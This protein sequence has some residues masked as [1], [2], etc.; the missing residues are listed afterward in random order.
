[1]STRIYVPSD[2]TACALGADEVAAALRGEVERRGLDA[3]IVRTGSRAMYWLEPLIE[4]DSAVGR[5][6]FSNVG[7]E[8]VG[9]LFEAGFPS[10]CEVVQATGPVV[11]IPFLK[12]QERLSFRRAGVV[13]PVSLDDYR[14]HGGLSGLERAL[15]LEPRQIVE[16]IRISGLRGRGGAAF[17][18]GI[19]WQAVHDAAPGQKYIVCNAE[20]GDSGNYADR[21]MLESDPFQ[22]I[23]GM[24]I[25]GIA[26]GASRGYIYLRSEYPKA[27]GILREAIAAAERGG[28]LGDDI[29]GS[30][31]PFRLELRRG[32]GSYICGEET[33]LLNSLEGGRGVV[34]AKPP[35]PAACGLFGRPTLVS[36]VLTLAAAT[37][38]LEHGGASYRNLGHDR[39][40]GTL[41]CQ[42]GGNIRRGGLV[43]LA[44]GET[45]RTLLEDFGGGSASGRP[46]RAVQVGGPLGAYLPPSQWDT[47]LDYEAFAAIDAMV[48]H[49]GIVAF[50][51]TV[52]MG[53][54]ARYAME[55]CAA[56][57]CG[58]CTPC[59]IGSVRG[60][61]LI[62]RIRAGE[63]RAANRE[64][65]D[66]LCE[67]MELGSLCALGGL[68][69]MP[70][71]SAL[72]YFAEDFER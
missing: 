58:K 54:Q 48:G 12:R 3:Q 26:L 36:N 42:L 6:G 68:T 4:V 8:D 72:R 27:F 67:T 37:T 17:P 45:L 13:D 18:A 44:F 16:E 63:N 56:E 62:D 70:V 34:R 65:L 55:F 31:I 47:P 69:P 9:G 21:L 30:G 61:E 40:R 60:A 5:I 64:L 41:A 28:L 59:R 38:I 11:E 14:A 29:C 43:E 39:S 66:E 33:A 25:A 2:T 15:M 49:G 52:D 46:L 22:V 19:K 71:R 23:E 1:M 53:E 24:L 20:E 51:D 35:L 57:S 10:P 50:D 32:A 7:A